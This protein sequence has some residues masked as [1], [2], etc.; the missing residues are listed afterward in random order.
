MF[1]EPELTKSNEVPK[2]THALTKAIS[3]KRKI[4]KKKKKE[5]FNT[6]HGPKN[7]SVIMS[8]ALT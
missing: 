1:Y 3:R 2:L 4:R 7:Y 5:L 8:T 6:L